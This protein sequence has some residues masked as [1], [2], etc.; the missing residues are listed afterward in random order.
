MLQSCYPDL[1]NLESLNILYN[2]SMGGVKE[3]IKCVFTF[4]NIS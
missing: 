4:A 2:G 1:P 3:G